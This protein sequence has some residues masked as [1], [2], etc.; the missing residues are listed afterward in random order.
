M[1]V[2]LNALQAGNRSGTGRYT[3]ELMHALMARNDI[4]LSVAWP[5]DAL[6][7]SVPRGL[8]VL[9][10]RGSAVSRIIADQWTFPRRYSSSFHLLHYPANVG[11][12]QG[13]GRNILTVHDLSFCHHPEWFTR[14]RAAYYRFAV[15]ASARRAARIIADSEATRNDLVTLARVPE[16]RIDVVPLGVSENF[17]PA[18]ATAQ[19]AVRTRYHLPE[20]FFLFMGTLEPR[21]N[22][23]RLVE[24]WSSLADVIPEDLVLAGRWGWRREELMAA[25]VKSG[26]RE[27]IHL[28]DYIAY[29]DLPAVI[30]AARAFVWPSLF[31]GFGLPPLEAM[32]CGTPVLTSNTSSLPE[33]VGDAA[34]LVDP[35][36]PAEIAH[37]LRR[38]SEDNNL[39]ADLAQRGRTR[40]ATFT[41]QRT[42][43]ETVA[44]YRRALNH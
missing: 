5:L 9:G 27:R 30:S 17:Q 14:S 12:L 42:A 34:L 37:G 10:Q 19:A 28:T 39:R 13:S 4:D 32:A 35:K 20:R 23:P 26:Q 7:D 29:A 44:T 16:D 43:E 31:E 2:L 36:S 38:L 15:P 22:L 40:A 6:P 33:V 25:L 1:R 24:A 11:P 18:D 3:L 21:K 41:W 8:Q